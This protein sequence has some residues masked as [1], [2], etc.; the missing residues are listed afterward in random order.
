MR[1]LI[2]GGTGLLGPYLK[3]AFGREGDVVTIGRDHGERRLDVTE[4]D[5]VKALLKER[6]PDVVLNCLALTDVDR[7]EEDPALAD[8]LNRGSVVNLV[9]NISK[10]VP[11]VQFST[12]QVY[13][14]ES[15]PYSEEDIGP[16]NAYGRSK[17]A[18]EEAALMHANALVLRVNFFG[19]SR[20]PGRAS[21]SD[22]LLKS[23]TDKQPMTLFTDSFFSPLR[24]NTVAEITRDL[25]QR[26][27]AGTFNLGSRNGASK[28]SFAV[29]LCDR[30]GLSLENAV[31]GESRNIVGRAPRPRDM[32]MNVSKIEDAAEI[33]LP[34]LAQE[35]DAY[36]A[37]EER[38]ES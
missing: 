2:F 4:P 28:A 15:G 21:L 17:R 31:E 16:I 26:G 29:R 13:N 35:I 32:R 18:G 22:W 3:D 7:C 5:A 10:E 23:A 33:T 8:R 11:F 24:M 12:D 14:G 37:D 6:A 19:R 30:M 36:R 9:R 27:L 20:T 25:V 1:T 34:T 38:A